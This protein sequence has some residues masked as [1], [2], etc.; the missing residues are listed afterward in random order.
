ME[1]VRGAVTLDQSVIRSMRTTILMVGLSHGCR[2][3]QHV[4]HPSCLAVAGYETLSI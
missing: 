4:R 3:P 2:R 1:F